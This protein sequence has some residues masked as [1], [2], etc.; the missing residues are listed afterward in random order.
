ME[1]IGDAMIARWQADLQGPQGTPGRCGTVCGSIRWALED[2]RVN[3]EVSETLVSV[4]RPARWSNVRNTHDR[5][6]EET[7]LKLEATCSSGILV[8]ALG[9]D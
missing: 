2:C 1:I 7:T 5:C 8:A 9:H 6:S 4:S 3:C